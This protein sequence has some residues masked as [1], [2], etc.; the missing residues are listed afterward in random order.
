LPNG[1][2]ALIKSAPL[3]EEGKLEGVVESVLDV[4]ALKQAQEQAEAANRAKSDFLANMSHEIRT[5]MTAILGYADL[6]AEDGT[7]AIDRKKHID[8][9]R[10]NGKVLLELINDILDLSKIESNQLILEEC[11]C[12]LPDILEAV[13]GMAAL[14]ASE[15]EIELRCS[16]DPELPEMI[17]T[18]PTRLRQI[19]VNLVGN[20][21]KFTRKGR[22]TIEA[23]VL[24]QSERANDDKKK[25]SSTRQIKISVIDTGIGIEPEKLEKIFNPFTQ[26]DSSTTR[27]FGGTGLG[28]AIS[29][30]LI[31]KMGGELNVQSQY[32][33]GSCFSVSLPL[34]ELESPAGKWPPTKEAGEGA[35][36]SGAIS[37][38]GSGY[39]QSKPLFRGRVLL[40]E[41]SPDLQRLISL[42]LEKMG[43]EVTLA[44]NGIL[45]I[46]TCMCRLEKGEPYDLIFMDVQMPVMDGLEATRR[47]REMGWDKPIVSLT[48]H[49]M[50]SDREKCLDSGA[51]DYLSKPVTPVQLAQLASKYLPCGG[52]VDAAR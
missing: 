42:L 44:S 27:R 8:T 13:R 35:N 40:V 16:I 3:V 1:T 20:A 21:V 11:H 41:D 38:D 14:Q 48:A 31:E 33:K 5:P 47:L 25:K 32:G 23:S 18:D 49:A 37:P 52:F 7:G 9:I 22:V 39:K 29:R 19:L 12:S 2:T 10:R 6:L 46:E 4:T 28:L 30:R 36:H 15:K 50:K 43:L 51:N 34:W 17:R 26:A 45:A 24:A